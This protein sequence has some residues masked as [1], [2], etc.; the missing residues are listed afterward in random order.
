MA[1]FNATGHGA[2]LLHLPRRQR[3]RHDAIVPTRS[4]GGR[5]G[6][7]RLR[8]RG[9]ELGGLPGRRRRGR[10]VIWRRRRQSERRVLREAGT[11][12]S[13]PL[14][15]LPWRHRLRLG[16]RHRRR[17]HRQR[18][19]QRRN[20]VG[21]RQLPADRRRLRPH[22]EQLRRVPE[23]V[24]RGRHARLLDLLRRHRRRAGTGSSPAPWPSTTRAG[25]TSPATPT[26]PISRP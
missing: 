9:H 17:Q 18:L 24:R 8:R 12:R 6:G 3:R 5:C 13:V 15:H 4:R 10:H 20:D 11:D 14:R 1:K 23:Q 7:Q 21:Q 19:R 22:R 2:D 25:P 26:A 16:H